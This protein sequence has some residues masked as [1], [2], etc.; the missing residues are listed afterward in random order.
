LRTG[1]VLSRLPQ[2]KDAAIRN[3]IE[4]TRQRVAARGGALLDPIETPHETAPIRAAIDALLAQGADLVLIAG[5]SAVTDRADVA[6]AAIT[7]AGGR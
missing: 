6:P 1:L 4:A 3:T 5:A 2:L 7:E